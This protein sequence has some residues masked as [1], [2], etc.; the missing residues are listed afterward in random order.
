[1]AS[2][3]G[4]GRETWNSGAW[5]QQAPVEASGNGLTSTVGT[6]SLVTTNIF[7]V[8]GNQLTSS[9]GDATQASEYAATG[10]AS[11]SSLGT[12]PNPTIV[13]NQ[14]LTGWNRGVGTTV[15]LGWNAA[16]W[17]NGDFILT[18]SNGLSGAGLTASLGEEAPVIS[19]NITVTGLGTTSSTGTATATGNQITTPNGNAI[20]SSLGTETVTGSSTHTLT[21]IGLTSQI[22]D[23]NAQGV[24]QS[25]WNRGA[26]QV[27]GELIGWSDNLWNILETSYSLTGT[28]ASTATATPTINIDVVPTITGVGL[29]STAG[30]IGG[31]A[32]ATGVS[33][34]SSIGTFSISGDSQLTIVAASEPE[35][36]ISTGT[37]TVEIGKTAFPPGNA[38]TSSLGSLSVVGTSVV[39][40]SGVNLTGSLGTEVASTDV[41][42][43]GVGGFVT[44]TVTVISTASGNKYVIDGIQQDTLE[45]AE[46]NTYRF[47]Q[48]DSSN[49]GHPFRFSETPNGTHG[50]GSEYTTGVTTNGSPGYAGAYTQIT[51]ASSAP[52][53]YYYCTVHSAMGG[54]ANTPTQ[55]ANQF[56]ANGLTIT[57]APATATAG[58]I[59]SVTGTS[60]TSTLGEESQET[61]YLLPSV[62][63]TT[64]SGTPTIT[65]SS[66]LTLTGVSAT[67]NTGT[68][69]GTFW[70]QVDDS[71]SDISWTEVHKAA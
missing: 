22:G 28:Q 30:V 67:S 24:R 68:L 15:P 7:G 58:A 66:T 51:V 33:S 64:S 31:F 12:M 48:S 71:N 42:V 61:S 8:T 26:N 52:T 46:G 19:V 50:G 57:A 35:M 18:T 37:A 17:N 16:S 5:N 60:L 59:V 13:D 63:L 47:D 2:I 45:L 53:L 34:T 27:T 44:K 62:S 1:M 29:T 39:S 38:V 10:N 54:T 23:E 56:T 55:D 3:Q 9:I 20:T 69:G 32:Q 65:A 4:W 40:P 49:N 41:N 6:V 14:L 70:E 11:T 36:D 43:V 21:G 25:G